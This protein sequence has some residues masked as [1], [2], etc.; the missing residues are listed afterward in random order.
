MVKKRCHN[1]F[2]E[3][4]WLLTSNKPILKEVFINYTQNKRIQLSNNVFIKKTR[5]FLLI[6]NYQ[7]MHLWKFNTCT[8]ILQNVNN[9][10]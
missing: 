5:I 7:I 10:F 6:L 1:L 4:M 8:N 3:T 2:F 9:T